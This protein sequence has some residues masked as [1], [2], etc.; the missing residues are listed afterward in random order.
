MQVDLDPVQVA[1]I[2]FLLRHGPA[3]DTKLFEE[4]AGGVY[5]GRPDFLGAIS[6]LVDRGIIEPRLQPEEVSTW[7]VLGPLG[8]RLRGKIPA[9]V[10]AG[11]TIYL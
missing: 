5:A 1:I 11:V 4:A 9:G 7:F 3:P 10:R 6:S 8:N 2:V